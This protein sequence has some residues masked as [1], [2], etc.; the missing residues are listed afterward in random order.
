MARLTWMQKFYWR[1]LS[2]PAENR[3]LFQF[4]IEHPIGSVL[5]IGI[6]NGQRLEQVLSLVTVRPEVTQLRYA[7]V[8]LFESGNP[9]AGHLRLKDV[10]RKLAE[11]NIKAH[12]IPGDAESSLVRVSHTILP[13]DLIIV[14]CGWG[15]SSANGAALAQWLPRLAHEST[16]IFARK[17]REEALVSV[18]C[19]E[20]GV[21]RKA[22]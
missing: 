3:A 12:L 10:H 15:E 6:G 9:S 1:H 20:S 11:K 4:L 7:G 19:G 5:E 2:K 16:T 17:N 14:D 8:D 22:A 13:S 21:L 18:Q